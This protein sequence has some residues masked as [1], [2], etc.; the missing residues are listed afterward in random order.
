[1]AEEIYNV[2]ELIE[3]VLQGRTRQNS[4][5]GEEV[6]SLLVRDDG[7]LRIWSTMVGES[8]NGETAVAME[9]SGELK[10][11][12]HGKDSDGNV[13]P[14]RTN[15]DQQLQVQVISS[16]MLMAQLHNIQAVL[17]KVVEQL[18]LMTDVTL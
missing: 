7:T 2:R 5:G 15:D 8:D 16:A 13:D 14:F 17:E 9:N 6:I 12:Q 3:Q 11:V 4:A 1:M 10:V 18:A